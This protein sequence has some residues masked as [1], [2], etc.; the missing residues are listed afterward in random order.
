MKTFKLV[1]EEDVSGVSGTGTVAEGVQFEDGQCVISWL[2][3]VHSIA[4][5]PNVLQLEKIHGHEG[6]TRVVWDE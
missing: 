1:R 3:H 4:I 2:S 6:R 5:Y